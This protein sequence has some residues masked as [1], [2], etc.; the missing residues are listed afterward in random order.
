MSGTSA[1]NVAVMLTGSC[2]F[3]VAVMAVVVT[4]CAVKVA[5]NLT[6]LTGMTGAVRTG[7][8]VTGG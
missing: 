8:V 7:A 4:G 5:V 6:G 1:V 3:N 2:T